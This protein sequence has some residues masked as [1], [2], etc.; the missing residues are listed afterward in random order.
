MKLIMDDKE[1]KLREAKQKKLETAHRNKATVQ[2]PRR[3]NE[4]YA[5]VLKRHIHE[6]LN[7]GHSEKTDN[8]KPNKRDGQGR[9]N[10][11]PRREN[12]WGRPIKII[13]SMQNNPFHATNSLIYSLRV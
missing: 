13:H 4:T 10:V 7:P 8:T 2:L 5:D 1:Q 3:D 12:T 9:D 6:R 11:P